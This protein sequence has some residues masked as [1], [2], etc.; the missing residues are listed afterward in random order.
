MMYGG[1]PPGLSDPLLYLST[2][3][4]LL[5][6]FLLSLEWLWR[7]TWSFFER[8]ATLR[9]PVTFVRVVL[10][11]M[12]IAGAVRIGPRLWLFMR[13]PRLGI[14]QRLDLAQL[15]GQMEITAVLFFVL[16]WLLAHVG[17]PLVRYQLEKEP[18][19]L[20]LWPTFEQMKRP[21]KIGVGVFAIAFALT[22]MR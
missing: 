6:G 14:E 17:E 9:S 18:L 15:S 19:P 3:F 7:L 11:I 4:A 22:Y 20:H 5:L 16:A 13:W 2:I 21:I 12:L 1:Y 8:P 10:V